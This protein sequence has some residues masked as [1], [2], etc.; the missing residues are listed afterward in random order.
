MGTAGINVT[1]QKCL[2][3]AWQGG[4]LALGVN[5]LGMLQSVLRYAL[6]P[7]MLFGIYLAWRRD[8]RQSAIVL[9]VILYYLI[10]GSMLHTEL[11]YGLPMQALLFIFA[12]LAVAKIVESL[13]SGVEKQNRTPDSRLQTPD[14]KHET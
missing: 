2:P 5:T 14:L 12:G 10:V 4:L 11:R 9:S 8:P 7:L 3:P 13:G 1:S 6:L